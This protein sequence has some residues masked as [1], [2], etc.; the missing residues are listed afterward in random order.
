[1][2]KQSCQVNTDHQELTGMAL[3]R[4]IKKT[5][6]DYGKFFPLNVDRSLMIQNTI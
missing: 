4:T 6:V 5:F 1:M 3:A 2:P